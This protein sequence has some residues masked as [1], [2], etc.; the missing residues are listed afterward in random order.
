MCFFG[1]MGK[2]TR[3]SSRSGKGLSVMRCTVSAS[4]TLTS[5][6]ARTL[7]YWGDFF[8]W[9]ITRSKEYFT[10]AGVSVSP[11]WNFTPLRILNSHWV[12]VSA[13]HDVAME[14]SNSSLVFRCRSESNMLMLTR[15]PTRSKCMCGSSVGACETSATVRVSLR[16]R[17]ER[18]G[19]REDGQGQDEGRQR[20]SLHGVS[21]SVM[22]PSVSVTRAAMT[23]GLGCL[24]I[25]YGGRHAQRPPRPPC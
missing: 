12:S 4:I 6:I 18:R 2:N 22:G 21:S 1:T 14:G 7:P 25:P 8:V 23:S 3:R 15:M 13:F 10:S 17:R 16:L 20:P 11:L 19:Q 5:L 24:R 9:S